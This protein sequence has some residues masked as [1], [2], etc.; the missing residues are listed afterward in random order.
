MEEMMFKYLGT[1]TF[2]LT[3][4]FFQLHPTI[5]KGFE[6][7]VIKYA[8]TYIFKRYWHLQL[9]IIRITQNIKSWIFI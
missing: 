2:V 5:Q 3:R 6:I 8:Y 9:N 4:K 7:I 1:I